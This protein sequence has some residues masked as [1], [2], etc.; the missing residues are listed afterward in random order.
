MTKILK[1]VQLSTEQSTP[2]SADPTKGTVTNPF[3]QVEMAT[4]QE[5]GTWNGGYV[6][7]MGYIVPMMMM[8]D[9]ESSESTAPLLGIK[10]V[11]STNGRCSI[12]RT[13]LEEYK[14]KAGGSTFLLSEPLQGYPNSEFDC[15]NN[16]S[17]VFRGTLDIFKFLADHTDVE[18]DAS[19]NSENDAIIHTSYQEHNSTTIRVDNYTNHVH[20]HPRGE[21]QLLR[22]DD[23]LSTWVGMYRDYLRTVLGEN[24]GLYYIYYQ[25]FYIYMVGQSGNQSMP[26]FDTEVNYAIME[27][28][29]SLWERY[30]AFLN[31]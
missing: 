28:Y 16:S 14:I 7:G 26:C 1:K 22:S 11:F 5:E 4:L 12:H 8:N 19:F 23:D 9:L 21:N 6:E 17:L 29:S 30:L 15:S 31:S 27:Y 13:K 25:H 2:K 18:W 3:T 20:S 24:Q 10:Y